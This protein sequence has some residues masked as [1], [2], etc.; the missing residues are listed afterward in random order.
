M[1]VDL[2]PNISYLMEH[3]NHSCSGRKPLQLNA[4]DACGLPAA[5][6]ACYIPLSGASPWVSDNMPWKILGSLLQASAKLS[7]QKK[8]M[9][10]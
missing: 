4:S 6:A 1:K 10:P 7:T 5:Q 8:N 3:K 9:L 2:I